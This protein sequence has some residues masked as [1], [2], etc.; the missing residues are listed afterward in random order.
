LVLALVFVPSYSWL[1]AGR[2]PGRYVNRCQAV[3]FE[4]D[5]PPAEVLLIGASR[6]GFGIDDDI[7]DRAMSPE[8]E[9]RT[10]KIVLLGNADSDSNLA[11][12]T[13]L[14][15]RGAPKMLGIEVVITRVAGETMAARYGASLTN[16]SYALFG[17]DAYD[18]YLSALID[19][20]V[21]DHSDVY[22]RSHFP[23]PLKFFFEHLQVGFDNAFRELDRALD[24]LDDCERTVL[25][26]WEPVAAAPFT[27]A[28]PRPSDRKIANL[29]KE[30][31]RYVDVDVDSRRASGELAVMRDM[32]KI[33]R[34]AG[35]EK[36]FLYYFPSWGE[37]PDM[38]DLGR[39]AELVPTDGM[40]DVRPIISDPSK[41]GLDLQYRDRAHLTQ[42]AAYEVTAGFIDFLKELT[43]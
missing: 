25:P 26:V 4:D 35:V 18:G 19:N 16:R 7:V 32:V 6:T 13:Y 1:R 42:Y 14:R 21:L 11:L 38:I 20:G 31:E 17:A 23:S 41:P 24:P 9:H 43:K 10:E 8:G 15:E 33:A 28:A 34:E 12:R 5:A 40:F 30:I 29:N 39:V 2:V 36:I 37:T 22:A 27:D 3:V